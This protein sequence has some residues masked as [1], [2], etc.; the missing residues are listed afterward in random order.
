M[1]L[2][3]WG[4]T[5]SA[6][7]TTTLQLGSRCTRVLWLGASATRGRCVSGRGVLKDRGRGPQRPRHTHSLSLS[8]PGNFRADGPRSAST[9]VQSD[10]SP[11]PA[12]FTKSFSIS[13]RAESAECLSCA[14]IASIISPP[15]PR[16]QSPRLVLGKSLAARSS[17]WTTDGASKPAR[18][19]ASKPSPNS[20]ACVKTPSN[21]SVTFS[22]ARASRSSTQWDK[23]SLG[24]GRGT[25]LL[26]VQVSSKASNRVRLVGCAVDG[27]VGEV[28]DNASDTKG[29]K[30]R[31]APTRFT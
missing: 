23:E 11:L 25:L 15:T 22:A 21:S 24:K 8:G 31:V 3:S 13:S 12:A 5:D 29:M 26:S 28:R 7:T 1:S 14:A 4:L 19:T 10:R 30:R 20:A 16:I 17:P 6:I 18:A 9:S 2:R 27:R